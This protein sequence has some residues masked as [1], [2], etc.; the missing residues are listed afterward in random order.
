LIYHTV[1]AERTTHRYFLRRCLAE[2][3]SKAVVRFIAGANSLGIEMSYLST[4]I[5]AS[6]GRALVGV[7]R[8]RRGSAGSL[9]ATLTG[10]GATVGGYAMARTRLAAKRHRGADAPP[11][12]AAPQA[13]TASDSETL[14]RSR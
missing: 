2:G 8:R 7:A 10:V 3:R 6:L 5:P 1:P 13:L 12:I 14:G 11:A 9:V 4:T